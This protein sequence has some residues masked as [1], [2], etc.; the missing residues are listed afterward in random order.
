[1]KIDVKLTDSSIDEAVKK[2]QQYKISIYQKQDELLNRLASLG[3]S[4]VSMGFSRAMYSNIA[5][6]RAISVS[7]EVKGNTVT[8]R[9]MGEAVA[10]IEF[11][12]GVRYGNGYLGNKPEGIVPIGTYGKGYGSD[13]EGWTFTYGNQS[14]HTYGNRP[15]M[16]FYNTLK[17]IAENAIDV[18]RSLW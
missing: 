16:V 2:L 13:P 4:R 9:A 3:A 15:A 6:Q 18:A 11:G 5:Q 7:A 12:A 8:I 10:F 14:I 1:M 17:Y